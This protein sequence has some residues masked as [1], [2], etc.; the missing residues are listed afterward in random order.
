M[1]KR[2]WKM[3]PRSRWPR[4]FSLLTTFEVAP[5][6]FSAHHVRGGPARFL[7][8][9]HATHTQTKELET[10]ET[11]KQIRQ[12][13]ECLTTFAVG[14][15]ETSVKVWPEMGHH[16]QRDAQLR[17]QPLGRAWCAQV[18]SQRAFPPAGVDPLRW[19]CAVGERQHPHITSSS[20]L[21][22]NTL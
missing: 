3:P 19:A 7:L 4:T 8:D 10:E 6:V 9:T 2:R 13:H 14:P 1:C 11:N 12:T 16:L 17:N 22:Q 18:L 20:E 5:D 21:L 15:Y